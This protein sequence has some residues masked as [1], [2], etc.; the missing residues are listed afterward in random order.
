[1]DTKVFFAGRPSLARLRVWL[2]VGLLLMLSSSLLSAQP[3]PAVSEPIRVDS[4]TSSCQGLRVIAMGRERA[5]V[6]WTVAEGPQQGVYYRQR[7]NL[8]WEPVRQIAGPRFEQPRDLDMAFDAMGRLNMVWTALNGANRSVY[9]TRLDSSAGA[10]AQPVI[11]TVSSTDEARGDADFPTISPE[12]HGSLV[13]AWQESQAMRFM[14][15]A[16]RILEN[17]QLQD[18]GRVSGASLSGMTPQ[19]ISLSPLRIAWYEVSE[20]GN[21]LRVDEWKPKEGRW[22]PS[23]AERQARVFPSESQLLLETIPSGLVACW[24]D[25]LKD[26]RSAIKMSLEPAATPTAKPVTQT[27]ADPPGDH[28]RPHLSGLLPGRM[29]L[30]WQVFSQGSQLVRLASILNPNEKPQVVTVSPIG[31]RFASAPDHVTVGNWSAVVWTDELRDGGSGGVYFAEVN[32]L[33]PLRPAS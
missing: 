10:T 25:V 23:E 6:G 33:D 32:W 30:S 9:Y 24:Q 12:A 28:S 7:Q 22:R 17:G 31:Q 16:A 29:T 19:I 18:L 1:M 11:V 26:G 5:V 21:E 13:V 2:A 4:T 8:I 14:V 3:A 20:A 15:R 27:L